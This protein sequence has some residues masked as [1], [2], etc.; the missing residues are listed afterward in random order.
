MNCLLLSLLAMTQLVGLAPAEVRAAPSIYVLPLVPTEADSIRFVVNGALV[1]SNHALASTSCSPLRTDSLV[2]EVRIHVDLEH[3]AIPA[4]HP[5][6]T[7]CVVGPLPAGE[8]VATLTEITDSP[9]EPHPRTAS[10]HFTVSQGT[11]VTPRSWG[12]L[13]C[14]F[15]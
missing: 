12:T 9:S 3:L 10:V 1:D 2:V 15:R 8:Y 6:Q 14:L 13:R 5:Y 7:S 4:E 11:P